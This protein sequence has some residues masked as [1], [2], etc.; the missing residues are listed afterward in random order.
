MEK[1]VE[2]G[3]LYD[4]YGP[5]LTARQQ[6]IYEACIYE[7]LSLS[8]AAERFSVSRQAVHDLLKRCDATLREYEEK[9]GLIGRF[10]SRNA[11]LGELQRR[12]TQGRRED[13][14]SGFGK[15][16]TEEILGLL[17]QLQDEA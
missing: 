2:Q 8:E 11:E 10:R 5:L 16:E 3:F 15:A 6:E 4:F 9:L 13:G 12:I 17:E 1:I 7:D 14:S